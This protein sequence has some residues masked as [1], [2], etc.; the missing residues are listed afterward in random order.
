MFCQSPAFLNEKK[1]KKK[2]LDFVWIFLFSKKTTVFKKPEFKNA[3]LATLHAT[4]DYMRP[5]LLS[6]PNCCV[7]RPGIGPQWPSKEIHTVHFVICLQFF[8]YYLI[9][10]DLQLINFPLRLL[11]DLH[12][13]FSPGVKY[14][15]WSKKYGSSIPLHMVSKKSFNS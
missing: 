1:E 7:K 6:R 14:T 3:K 5:L 13:F 9:L 12:T 4:S 2:K 8:A 11:S 15:L 10:L